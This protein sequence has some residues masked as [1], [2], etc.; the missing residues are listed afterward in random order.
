MCNYELRKFSLKFIEEGTSCA[1]KL[2]MHCLKVGPSTRKSNYFVQRK[3]WVH[4]RISFKI[5]IFTRVGS[6]LHCIVR[7]RLI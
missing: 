2:L 7:K 5:N 1:K 4:F 3:K 6:M